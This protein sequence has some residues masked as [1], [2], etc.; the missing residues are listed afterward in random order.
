MIMIVNICPSADHISELATLDFSIIGQNVYKYLKTLLGHL[1]FSGNLHKSR[2]LSA[3]MHVPRGSMEVLSGYQN[4]TPF[5]IFILKLKLWAGL[6]I[7]FGEIA[8]NW[9]LGDHKLFGQ[10]ALALVT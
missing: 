1:I 7:S 9:S 10:P 2:C 4:M 8:V 5:C 6:I 3:L